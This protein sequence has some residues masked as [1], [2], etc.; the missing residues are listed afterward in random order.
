VQSLLKRTSIIIILLIA[1]CAGTT[2]YAQSASVDLAITS[3]PLNPLPLEKVTL[4]LQS[5]STD[6]SQADIVWS[7]NSK[8][9]ATGK[10]RTTIS[11]AAPASG[12]TG[13]VTATASGGFDTTAATII[14][15]PASLDLL[16]EG[17]AS[18]T[19]PF[20]KGLPLPSTGGKIRMTAIPSINAP[21][22][23]SFNWKRN[24]EAVQSA[25][26]SGKSTYLFTHDDLL[27]TEAV[28]VTETNGGFSGT[29]SASVTPGKPV[30]AGYFNNDGFIDYANGSTAVLNTSNNG[31]LIHFEPYFIS[32]PI[33]LSHD[34]KFSYTDDNG[35]VLT[36][37][38]MQ[39]ELGLSR[40]DNGGESDFTT[41][42]STVVFSLQN[43][44]RRFT[45][46][47]N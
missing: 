2:A 26:G 38:K 28:E 27:N 35:N 8:T 10:G 39:N 11:I 47:F 5:F 6:L 18:Y 9:I 13:T 34:L 23:L 46:N 16:W 15:R 37:S 7:Y 42:I 3:T 14:L 36:P 33:S 20:Y 24:G 1:V 31:V 25:S 29:G 44:V 12:I 22:Q 32:S 43:I 40:P 45:V 19:A 41:A 21:K 4:S 17:A 30:V